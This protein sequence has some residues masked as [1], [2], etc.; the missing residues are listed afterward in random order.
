MKAFGT[1]F[2]KGEVQALRWL[3]NHL[4]NPEQRRAVLAQARSKKCSPALIDALRTQ[5]QDVLT[6]SREAHLK[7][8]EEGDAAVVVT[9]QQVGL[10]L[11]PLYTI[12][13]AATAIALAKALSKESGHPVVPL[14]WLQTEDHD[15]AEIATSFHP[16]HHDEPLAL[17]ISYDPDT[18][19]SVEHIQLGDELL[20]LHRQLN[21]S[22]GHLPY[23]E[24]TLSWWQKAYKPGRSMS[25]AFAHMLMKIF[26]DEGLLVLN[27]RTNAL[28]ALAAPIHRQCLEQAHTINEL[29]IER[30]SALQEAGFRVQ[31][32][33]RKECSLPFFHPDGVEGPR[34][35]LELREDGFGLSGRPDAFFSKAFIFETLSHAPMQFST[36]AL[37]RPLLQ[38]ILLP[39]AAYVGGPGEISYFAQLDPLYKQ[40]GQRMPMI[41]P[42]A[43]FTHIEPSISRTLESLSLTSQ[44]LSLPE[45]EIAKRY[46]EQEGSRLSDEALK[47]NLYEPFARAL[48]NFK[49]EI[50]ALEPGF[51]KTVQKTYGQVERIVDKL[52]GKIQNVRFHQDSQRMKQVKDAQQTLFPFGKPQ[53]RV[54]ALPYFLALF[55]VQAFKERLFDA[56]G[57]TFPWDTEHQ[58]LQW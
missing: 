44:D 18:R 6:P 47:A 1:A 11:G 10:F 50:L 4:N 19:H 27:P 52:S 24:E 54:Y 9:G 34:Y 3:S 16:R 12:H 36:S 55:G 43:R 53:E 38:D 57:E 37:M 20:D 15:T 21:E 56:I 8:L 30:E 40:L 33:I 25:D 28:A 5:H 32:P 23:A 46:T 7:A 39:T 45:R 41:V 14:F 48:N 22:M 49:D 17:A 29:L 35:R 58:E 51:E 13:K 31:I 26:E 42:R 2:L